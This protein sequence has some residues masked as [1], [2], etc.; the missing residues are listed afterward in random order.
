MTFLEKLDLLMVR[1]GLN[2]STLSKKCSIP[3]TTIDGWYKKGYEGVKLVTVKKLSDCFNVPL[4]FWIEESQPTHNNKKQHLSVEII[5]LLSL[6]DDDDQSFVLRQIRG[7][8]L[9]PKYQSKA[10]EA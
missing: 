6:L 7:L 1:E 8:L 2:K 3:Y 9:D 5:R 4:D 10:K